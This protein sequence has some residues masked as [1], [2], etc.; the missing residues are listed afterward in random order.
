MPLIGSFGAGSARG[1]GKGI[2]GL[3]FWVATGGSIAED[4]AFKVH[5]FTGN[6]TFT[7]TQEADEPATYPIS[8]LLVA[9][10]GGG[11]DTGG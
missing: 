3:K 1:F 7:I 11:G 2:G 6:S 8:Y 10:G 5:T 9:G 4:G